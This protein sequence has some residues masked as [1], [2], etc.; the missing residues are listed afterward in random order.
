MDFRGYRK[1]D[2]YKVKLEYF[3]KNVEIKAEFKTKDVILFCQ[4][5]KNSRASDGDAVYMIDKMFTPLN[6][7]IFQCT[8]CL[9]SLFF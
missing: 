1:K 7:S 8:P 4:T 3:Y 2:V 9:S 6:I 5:T